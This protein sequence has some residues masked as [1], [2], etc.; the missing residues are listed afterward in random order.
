MTLKNLFKKVKGNKESFNSGNNNTGS[1]NNGNSNTGACN[2]GN[3]NSGFRNNG[4]YNSGNFNDGYR[5]SGNGNSG[6]H[7][8]GYQ[9]SGNRNT[10]KY[11]SGNFN[12]GLFNSCNFSSGVFCTT[13]PKINI[14]NV[15]TD[16]TLH[17]FLGSKYYNAITSSDFNLTEWVPYTEEEMRRDKNK[18]ITG[19]YLRVYTYKEACKNWWE[20]MSNKNKAIICS[21]PNFDAE[22]FKQIT[23]IDV[24]QD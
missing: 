12:S 13:E 7:N 15:P 18:K 22:I 3:G 6:N 20:G 24:R 10:G 9:N 2:N 11:N 19:G 8:S 4:D 5:N 17:E 23:G 14:F 1:C 16:M 21:M